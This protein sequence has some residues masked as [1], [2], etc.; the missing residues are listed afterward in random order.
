MSEQIQL[1]PGKSL[2]TNTPEK[3]RQLAIKMED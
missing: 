1:I 2:I 3:G